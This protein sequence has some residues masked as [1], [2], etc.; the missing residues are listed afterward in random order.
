MQIA[1]T[2]LALSDSK[3]LKLHAWPKQENDSRQA[4]DGADRFA[5]KWLARQQCYQADSNGYELWVLNDSFG[6]LSLAPELDGAEVTLISDSAVS[7][8]AVR[9]NAELNHLQLPKLV[10]PGQLPTTHPRCLIARV[11]RQ[12]ALLAYQLEH[13][14]ADLPAGVP[15]LVVG[16]DKHLPTNLKTLLGNYLSNIDTLPGRF[17]AHGFLGYTAGLRNRSILGKY[18]NRYHCKPVSGDLVAHAGVFSNDKTDPGGALLC[19]YLPENQSGVMVDL[20]CGAG[21]VGIAA[22]IKNPCASLL[23]VDESSQAI[24]STEENV[25]RLLPDRLDHC[26]FHLGNGLNALTIKA[27]WVFLNPPFHQGNAV[28]VQVAQMLIDHAR[29]CLK[30]G[31]QLL[32]VQNRH[33]DYRKALR[34]KFDR[35]DWVGK[36]PRFR[37]CRAIC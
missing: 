31:G 21:M 34:A 10:W 2:T 14:T 23:F 24:R 12:A 27:D 35:L 8:E 37:V 19:D 30:V 1:S 18:I 5:L 32:L 29:S 11:P 3:A 26:Q 13:L 6:A 4:W 33:L 36:D 7:R 16:M 17:K 28:D 25:S 22:L 9:F 15:V 20:G